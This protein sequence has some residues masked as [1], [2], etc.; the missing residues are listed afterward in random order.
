MSR[1]LSAVL[2]LCTAGALVATPVHGQSNQPT[3][4]T[5]PPPPPRPATV[6]PT[7]GTASDRSSQQDQPQV[8][9]QAQGQP[10]APPVR[11]A[12]QRPRPPTPRSLPPGSPVPP[13]APARQ[14][15][16]SL[17]QQR[18]I[19]SRGFT[20]EALAARV[21][22]VLASIRYTACAPRVK[23][24]VTALADGQ[25]VDFIVE[26]M[27]QLSNL[28][29]LVVTVEGIDPAA[30]QVRHSLLHVTPNCSGTYTQ[31]IHWAAPCT[32]VAAQ[33]FPNFQ[34]ERLIHR[35]VQSW[36]A[37]NNLQ[38]SL[39]PAGTGCVSIKKEMFR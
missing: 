37:G 30:S 7:W 1:R 34:P 18:F 24:I 28:G 6:S 26:P 39:L 33:A 38:L 25:S 21:D 2:V 9:S 4:Q 14:E 22:Q 16:P 27:A 20:G 15:V 11:P 23:Q 35:G 5:P 8:D 13:P 29:T 10:V 3:W 17:E 31:T 32:V 19:P 12:P 36:R